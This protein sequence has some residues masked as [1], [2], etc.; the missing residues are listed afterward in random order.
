MKYKKILAYFESPELA[1]KAANRLEGLG[2]RDL[3]INNFQEPFD[4]GAE[5]LNPQTAQMENNTEVTLG[6]FN[7][8]PDIRALLGADFSASGLSTQGTGHDVLVTVVVDN[9]KRQQALDII[10]E[11]GGTI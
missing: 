2:I 3:Q 9:N 1:Q 6:L 5:I 8:G 10:K 4:D 7:T 11:A